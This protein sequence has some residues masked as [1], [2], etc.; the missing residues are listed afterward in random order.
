MLNIINLC[1]MVGMTSIFN[2]TTPV[3]NVNDAKHITVSTTVEK[4]AIT[5]CTAD[6]IKGLIATMFVITPDIIELT[7]DLTT[8]SFYHPKGVQISG[9]IFFVDCGTDCTTVIIKSVAGGSR[10]FKLTCDI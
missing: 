4:P 5:S 3:S 10:V 8:F 6:D 1:F 7:P 2:P 9:S